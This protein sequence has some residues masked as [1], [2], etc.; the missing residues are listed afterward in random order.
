MVVKK[1]AYPGEIVNSEI[2][3]IISL[4]KQINATENMPNNKQNQAEIASVK[5]LNKN[6]E[7]LGMEKRR[8]EWNSLIG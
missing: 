5:I 7:N 3:R 1:S 2:P 8:M 4:M 6:P